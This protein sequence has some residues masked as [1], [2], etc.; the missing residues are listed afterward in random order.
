MRQ[1]RKKEAR[2]IGRRR[3]IRKEEARQGGGRKRRISRNI[4]LCYIPGTV[5]DVRWREVDR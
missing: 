1:E 4:V 2:Q 3:K 5:A